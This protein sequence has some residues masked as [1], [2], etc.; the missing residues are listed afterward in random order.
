MAKTGS[1]G[2]L[3]QRQLLEKALLTKQ[4]NELG[5]NCFALRSVE[6]MEFLKE[7]VPDT[8]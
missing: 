8:G 3:V 7:V 4:A 6:H 2:N 5:N 1:G